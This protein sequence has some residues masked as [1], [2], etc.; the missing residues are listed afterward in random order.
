MAKA[1]SSWCKF[2]VK[3]WSSS[4]HKHSKLQKPKRHVSSV[5][6]TFESCLTL[7]ILAFI[8]QGHKPTIT[9]LYFPKVKKCRWIIS[10]PLLLEASLECNHLHV[11]HLHC[12]A[13]LHGLHH[14]INTL[15]LQKP[16]RHASSAIYKHLKPVWHSILTFISQGH[17]PTITDLY[18]PKVN[19]WN[20][21]WNYFAWRQW[22]KLRMQPENAIN[23]MLAT[24]IVV[25]FYMMVSTMQSIH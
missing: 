16:G 5:I 24:F 2:S 12:S 25:L 7:N 8:L 20:Y 22:S 1:R 11:G 4:V 9:D 18:F 13:A 15:K 10:E 23:S 14:A 17:K 21:L 3:M 6:Y 19:R